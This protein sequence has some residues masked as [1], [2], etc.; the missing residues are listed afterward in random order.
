LADGLPQSSPTILHRD[1]K[2]HNLLI[3]ENWKAKVSDF[4]LSKIVESVDKTMTA[5]GTPSWAAPEVCM[6]KH[7]S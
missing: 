1:L 2:S 3:D 4:G 5:C 6:T 7:V